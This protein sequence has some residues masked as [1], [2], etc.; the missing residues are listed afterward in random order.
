MTP[1]N[2]EVDRPDNMIMRRKTAE[3]G[4]ADAAKDSKL[5]RACKS[6][7]IR[8]GNRAWASRRG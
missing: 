7:R 6:D 1:K 2:S 3:I 4:V 8:L 5:D